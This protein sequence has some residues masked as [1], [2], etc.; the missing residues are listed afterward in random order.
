MNTNITK[1][2]PKTHKKTKHTQ[3]I[4][5]TY[6]DKLVLALPEIQREPYWDNGHLIN[7]K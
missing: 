3:K 5:D 6:K 2:T 4:T 1:K 7:L